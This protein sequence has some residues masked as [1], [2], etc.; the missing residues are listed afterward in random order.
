MNAILDD[1]QTEENLAGLCTSNHY[2]IHFPAV[3]TMIRKRYGISCLGQWLSASQEA[4]CSMQVVVVIVLVAA[5]AVVV[6]VVVGVAVV[7]CCC[8][9]YCCRCNND[10]TETVYVPLIVLH[11]LY[12]LRSRSKST[13]YEEINPCPFLGMDIA[14]VLFLL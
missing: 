13:W 4:L 3:V 11:I 10:A 14:F 9:F 6:V 2:I 12:I 5:A 1:T 7:F 8:C